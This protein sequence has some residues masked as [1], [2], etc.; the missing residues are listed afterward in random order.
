MHEIYDQTREICD[1]MRE[2][3][4]QMEEARGDSKVD[5]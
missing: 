3:Y 5:I 4:D 1:H 2:I